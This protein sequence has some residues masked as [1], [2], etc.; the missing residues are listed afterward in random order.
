MPENLSEDH[1]YIMSHLLI[2]WQR[3]FALKARGYGNMHR[4]LG[5][6]AQYVDLHRKCAKLRMALWD[7]VDTSEWDE[8][9]REVAMDM[10]GHLFL[11]IAMIDRAE[12]SPS[13]SPFGKLIEGGMLYCNRCQSFYSPADADE[14]RHPDHDETEG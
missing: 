7:E 2:E 9:P 11:T 10:I 12:Q 14:H 1:G 3:L 13:K 4:D 8:T 6:K 5:L